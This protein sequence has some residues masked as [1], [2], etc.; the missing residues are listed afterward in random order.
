[1]TEVGSRRE[2]GKEVSIERVFINTEQRTFGPVQRTPA[3]GCCKH[4]RAEGF[5]QAAAADAI[6]AGALAAALKT[7][8]DYRGYVLITGGMLFAEQ[9]PFRKKRVLS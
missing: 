6:M 7:S 1:V 2:E 3:R 8:S 9:G 4:T 5:A